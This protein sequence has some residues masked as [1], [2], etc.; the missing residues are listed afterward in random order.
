MEHLPGVLPCDLFAMA[1]EFVLGA[2]SIA[3]VDRGIHVAISRAL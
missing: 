2:Q 3:L 1:V